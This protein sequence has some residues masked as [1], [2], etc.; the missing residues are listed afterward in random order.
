[1]ADLM[2]LLELFIEMGNFMR[3]KCQEM[4]PAMGGVY[5]IVGKEIKLKLDGGRI[6]NK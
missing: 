6:I 4:V 3:V 5:V 2:E 1:V